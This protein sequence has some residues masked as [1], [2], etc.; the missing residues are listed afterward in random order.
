MPE[1]VE[2]SVFTKQPRKSRMMK[3]LLPKSVRELG[4]LPS[5]SFGP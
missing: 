5:G 4:P 2:H 3:I 1:D